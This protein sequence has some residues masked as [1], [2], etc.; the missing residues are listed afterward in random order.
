M[1][2]VINV[3]SGS[4]LVRKGGSFK[5]ALPSSRCESVIGNRIEAGERHGL[6]YSTAGFCALITLSLLLKCGSSTIKGIVHTQMNIL[7]S[8][9]LPHV[10]NLNMCL[11]VEE[12]CSFQYNK[13]CQDLKM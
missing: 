4:G 13:C 2:H 10:P 3:Q 1:C 5:R 11:F 9:A 7:S 6:E 12:Q 8:F